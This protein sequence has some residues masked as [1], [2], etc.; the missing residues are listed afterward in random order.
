[1]NRPPK[2]KFSSIYPK[3][4]GQKKARLVYVQVLDGKKLSRDLIEYDT[5]KYDGTYY[6][7]PKT[8][9]IQ[10]VFIG[11]KN[12][13]FCTLRKYSKWKEEYYRNNINKV[14]DIVIEL[15]ERVCNVENYFRRECVYYD[16]G[17]CNHPN[18][19]LEKLANNKLWCESFEQREGGDED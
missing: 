11:D 7:L 6:E 16:N 18:P 12:I 14:F 8:R 4:W 3:L 2:I 17:R 19:E 15:K 13:P 9:L 5:K 1:M 10:L